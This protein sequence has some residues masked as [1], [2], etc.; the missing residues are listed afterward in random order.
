MAAV[1]HIAYAQYWILRTEKVRSIS[2]PISHSYSHLHG[3][4]IWLRDK[5]L[6]THN[7]SHLTD[8]AI[9]S[10]CSHFI[11]IA[12]PLG[13]ALSSL[14]QRIISDLLVFLVVV[15][16]IGFHF[17]FSLNWTRLALCFFVQHP[18]PP[19]TWVFV[20]NSLFM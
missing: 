16:F 5:G 12:S 11:F 2:F 4:L 14:F 17:L 3:Y 20:L 1:E 7:I 10:N 15:G 9:Q 19:P 6:R 18:P 13:V 8:C